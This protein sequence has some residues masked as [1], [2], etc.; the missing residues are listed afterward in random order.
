M[1][2][3][4]ITLLVLLLGVAGSQNVST[5]ADRAS[6]HDR[7][8]RVAVTFDDLPMPARNGSKKCDPASVLR[9]NRRLLDAIS[10]EKMPATGLVT[11][12]R[13]CGSDDD[14]VLREIFELWLESGHDL[15]NHSYSHRDLNAVSLDWY[16]SDITRNQTLIEEALE[17]DGQNRRWFRAPLLHMGDTNAKKRGL[18]GYLEEHGYSLAP[19]T[20]DNQEWV[21]AAVYEHALRK[22][23]QELAARIVDGYVE[24]LDENFA[25]YEKLSEQ[26]FDRQIAQVLLLHANALN[27][28]HLDR[29][30]AMLRDRGYRFVS[31]EE[32]VGD[33]AYDHEDS[34]V[35]PRGLSWLQRWALAQ[36][37]V[38]DP[39]PREPEWIAEA[40]RRSR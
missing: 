13:F 15:G 21:F 2:P 26:L 23:N 22:G 33:P 20:I 6:G 36:G 39:E 37:I 5:V 8:L 16:V 35:G 40:F 30:A 10:E 11:G 25:Y 28:D 24:H 29:V 27:T 32:A 4:V 19:V 14:P 34:Y 17:K 1:S 3:H 7:N 38:P 31:L 12:S 9:D 18:E